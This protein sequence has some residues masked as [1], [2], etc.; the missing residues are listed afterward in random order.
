M[1]Q[2]TVMQYIKD[3]SPV[4]LTR[5]HEALPKGFSAE[6]ALSAFKSE[7]SRTP[8]LQRC[9]PDSLVKSVIQAAQLGL[10]VNGILGHAY[11]VPYG[12]NCQ[13]M[14]GYR[15]MIALARRSGQ[16]IS[17]YAQAV[18]K[19]DIFE[20]EF[21][22]E[23]KLRHVPAVGDRGELI[24]AYAISKLE[25]TYSQAGKEG[26]QFDVMSRSDIDKIK[27]RSQSAKGA[28]SP[29]KTDYEEMAKKTVLRRLFKYLPISIDI[30]EGIARE[31]VKDLTQDYKEAEDVDFE[32]TEPEN[33][34][35]EVAN[36]LT[37]KT[38]EEET[39]EIADEFFGKEDSED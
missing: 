16:I 27:S 5:M 21:G 7:I 23:E 37:K 20:F 9:S 33:Q 34:A 30:Q 38:K 6:K 11:L 31:E 4:I 29:W 2:Q 35:T 15:G 25:N 28:Y 13:F 32:A 8:A 18:Y 22:L 26:I 3:K 24:Y 19:N 36:K 1:S 39:K 12:A 14:L 17:I 10:E